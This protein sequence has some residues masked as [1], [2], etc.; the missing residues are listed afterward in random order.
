VYVGR[1]EFVREAFN[2]ALDQ[3]ELFCNKSLPREMFNHR[4]RVKNGILVP[5]SSEAS[6]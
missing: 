4:C 6:V 5:Y 2:N 3:V 1:Y